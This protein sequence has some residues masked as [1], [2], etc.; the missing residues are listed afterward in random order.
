MLQK[1]FRFACLLGFVSALFPAFVISAQD[2]GFALRTSVNYRTQRATLPLTEAQRKQAD[3]LARDA[4]HAAPAERYGNAVQ[5]YYHGFAVMRGLEWTPVYEMA[6]PLE[7]RLDRPIGDPG[8]Q[9]IHAEM[10]VC[11]PARCRN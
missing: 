1:S 10:P 2:A 11:Q 3:D 6:S 5:T 8:K 4:L 9:I 7:G